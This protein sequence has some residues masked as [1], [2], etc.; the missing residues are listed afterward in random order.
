MSQQ[1]KEEKKKQKL[2]KVIH[3]N[4]GE[5]VKKHIGNKYGWLRNLKRGEV[6]FDKPVV[7]LLPGDGAKKDKQAN[8]FVKKFI[9]A[10]G[11]VGVEDND[12]QMLATYYSPDVSDTFYES[13]QYLKNRNESC[14]EEY[15]NP[16]YVKDIYNTVIRPA[17]FKNSRGEKQSAEIIAKKFRNLTIVSHCFGSFVATMLVEN[18]YKDM[19]NLHFTEDEIKKCVGEIVN[20]S[21]SPRLGYHK[22]NEN[23]LT[24]GFSALNDG[25]VNYNYAGLLDSIYSDDIVAS[26]MGVGLMAEPQRNSYLYM[27]GD[28]YDYKYGK[29]NVYVGDE[30]HSFYEYVDE[31][32]TTVY[33]GE[34]APNDEDIEIQK[35][36]N[37][38]NFSRLI[39]R[40]FQNAVSL[41]AMGEKRTIERVVS[42]E[43]PI[44]FKQGNKEDNERTVP[45]VFDG[46]NSEFE[47]NCKKQ[48]EKVKKLRM[49][50]EAIKK[51]DA[52]RKNENTQGNS[53]IQQTNNER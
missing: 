6:N 19:Q 10:M 34:K 12:I 39:C 33:W 24:I 26:S 23:V 40:V 25:L 41:S 48:V 51:L 8:G 20:I 11:R 49:L 27:C 42:N 18:L 32:A 50:Y 38:K 29:P 9:W 28:T 3:S 43:T 16:Q 31:D 15:K 21:V 5:K 22:N 30:M 2:S 4:V 45:A 36:E 37:G 46:N 53:I 14:S 35:N 44:M 52:M 7:L 13:R 47:K 1:T 17:L